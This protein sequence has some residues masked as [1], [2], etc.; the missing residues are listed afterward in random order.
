MKNFVRIFVSFWDHVMLTLCNHPPNSII[1]YTIVL[2]NVDRN[3]NVI[4]S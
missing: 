1:N 4:V 2:N 3:I